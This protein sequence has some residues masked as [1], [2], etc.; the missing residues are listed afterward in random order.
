MSESCETTLVLPA[1]LHAR[2]AGELVRVA[3]EF[4]STVE[5]SF[6]DKS[7]NARSVLGLMS[8]GATAGQTVIV[9]ATAVGASSSRM[10]S[11]GRSSA[12]GC[13]GRL[14]PPAGWRWGPPTT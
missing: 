2:P 3:A 12:S 13:G 10:P 9:R 11:L 14:M 6:G 4:G 1:H 5:V 8:L 7:A